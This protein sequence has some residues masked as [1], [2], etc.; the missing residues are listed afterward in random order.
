MSYPACVDVVI[1]FYNGNDFINEALKS[2]FENDYISKI[3]IVVDLNSC[4]PSI[5]DIYLSG[6]KLKVIFN[7]YDVGGAGV[8]RSIG[9]NQADAEFVAFLDCDD[10]WSADKLRVQIPHMIS[11][12]LAF[13]FHGFSHF[14]TP[15]KLIRRPIVPLGS[16]NGVNFYKKKFTIGCLS[17]VINKNM[18]G[19]LPLITLKRRNDYMLWHFVIQCCES[20][21]FGWGGIQDVLG[22]HRI[23]SGSLSSSKFKSAIYY[24]KFLKSCGFP[25]STRLVYWCC[26]FI[27][28]IGS[29]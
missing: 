16:F 6:G 19:E 18:I 8:V 4:I 10:I 17:V 5:H 28:T 2:I 21:L 11:N 22:F 9:Y 3:F 29:R 15:N 13:S 27:N 25:L 23:T 14:L 7:N 12:N 24:Y 26:Y 1:P 20:R